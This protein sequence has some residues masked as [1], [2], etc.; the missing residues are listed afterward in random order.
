MEPTHFI[1]C[2]AI[3][4][5]LCHSMA[6]VT[7]TDYSFSFFLSHV[8]FIYCCFFLWNFSRSSFP[9]DLFIETGAI[10]AQTKD[11]RQAI[12]VYVSLSLHMYF[13]FLFFH[14][15]QMTWERMVKVIERYERLAGSQ[16]R[17][18]KK[19]QKDIIECPALN[20][21]SARRQVIY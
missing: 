5:Q 11:I 3:L 15:F 21:T 20:T 10:F 7:R 14:V 12:F 18:L 19:I 16:L 4:W 1:Y 17:E 8:W 2:N 13:K 6:V 9:F